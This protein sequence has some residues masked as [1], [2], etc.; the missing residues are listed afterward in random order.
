MACGYS[1]TGSTKEQT[2]FICYGAGANGKSKFL[3]ALRY[4][5]GDYA[6]D[7]PF[8]TFEAHIGSSVPNDLASL[9]G[10]RLVTSSETND[11]TRLN[12]ARLKSISGGDPITARYL[13][14]EFFT[15]NPKLKLWLAVNYLPA[16]H[17]NSLGF[18]RRVRTI[19]FNRTFQGNN[20][21]KDILNKLFAEG[22]GMLNWFI[23]GAMRWQKEGLTELP[24]QIT[25]ANKEYKDDSNILFAFTGEKLI[26]CPGVKIAAGELYKQYKEWGKNAG[27][28]DKEVLTSS[29][30]GRVMAKQYK[31][32][33]VK[34]IRYYHD[35]AVKGEEV[36][37][38]FD[39][40]K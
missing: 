3:A 35:I 6:F 29:I 8:S 14:Q 9:E 12:E 26:E 30:F 24:E 13:H 34:G 25:G 40:D 18:W 28:M 20:D 1:L 37:T 21:D 7:A 5:L 38:G 36:Q 31:R 32:T 15:F 4:I 27:L 11:G 17:D 33:T 10:M 22:P 2:L 39:G 23:E 16:I 19:P